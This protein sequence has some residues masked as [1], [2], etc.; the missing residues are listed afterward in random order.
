M[1]EIYIN[2]SIVKLLFNA[3]KWL[4]EALRPCKFLDFRGA[5]SVPYH[6]VAICV[7]SS[8]VDSSINF[9]A[10]TLIATSRGITVS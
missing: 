3:F 4:R 8:R 5:Y 1:T 2:M 10:N 7:L 6:P 9:F